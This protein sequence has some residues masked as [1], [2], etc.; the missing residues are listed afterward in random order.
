M[1]LLI[2]RVSYQISH[3]VYNFSDCAIREAGW[4]IKSFKDMHT[5][6]RV[7][8]VAQSVADQEHLHGTDDGRK[9]GVTCLLQRDGCARVRH[10]RVMMFSDTLVAWDYGRWI[11]HTVDVNI[12]GPNLARVEL[13]HLGEVQVHVDGNAECGE[14]GEQSQCRRL[15]SRRHRSL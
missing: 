2:I 11:V 15:L 14:I 5:I 13:G 9:I 6:I 8:A 10:D 3:H 7:G 12:K 4:S 1:T